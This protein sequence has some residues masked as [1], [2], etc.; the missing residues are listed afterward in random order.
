MAEPVATVSAVNDEPTLWP[1]RKLQAV[2]AAGTVTGG[3]VTIVSFL[4]FKYAFTESLP[5][6]VQAAIST[7]IG[8]MVTAVASFAA[9]YFTSPAPSET[10]VNVKE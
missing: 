8:G 3:L 1:T 7:L 6:D 10:V 5:T 4:I 9:G 2:G